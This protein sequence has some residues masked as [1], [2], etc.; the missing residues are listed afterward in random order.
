MP[1]MGPVP[2]GIFGRVEGRDGVNPFI[3]DWDEEKKKPKRK[4][5]EEAKRLL[6]EAGFEN[7]RGRPFVITFATPYTGV[8]AHPFINWYAKS[9]KLRGIGVVEGYD[10][11]PSLS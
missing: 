5:I 2:P 8:G 7:G 9:F 6:S 1:A 11:G 3:Y 4:T 10:K